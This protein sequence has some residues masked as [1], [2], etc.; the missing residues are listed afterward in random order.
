VTAKRWHKL[1]DLGLPVLLIGRGVYGNG[2]RRLIL[3][4]RWKRVVSGKVLW[5]RRPSKRW[6]ARERAANEAGKAAHNFKLSGGR[7]PVTVEIPEKAYEAAG[8]S[9]GE[10]LLELKAEAAKAT[11]RTPR[12]DAVLAVRLARAS[13]QAAAPVILEDRVEAV[14]EL[15]AVMWFRDAGAW[16]RLPEDSW[17]DGK[18]DCKAYF[19][20]V[21]REALGIPAPD[22]KA[23]E[24]G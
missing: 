7:P 6:L 2:P 23:R 4:W 3:A 12:L 24:D 10:A 9:A 21:A 20:R 18:P 8:G 22:R 1:A 15:L 13:V 14:A 16:E 11:H 19:R 17:S 5:P